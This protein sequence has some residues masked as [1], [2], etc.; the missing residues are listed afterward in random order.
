[1]VEKPLL[2][3]KPLWGNI[4]RVCPSESSQTEDF[5]SGGGAQRA[6]GGLGLQMLH[7]NQDQQDSLYT[8][9]PVALSGPDPK[10]NLIYGCVSV[11]FRPGPSVPLALR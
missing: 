10:S 5:R 4:S 8:M 7:S 2:E 3:R 1:M 9:Y 11:D 6:T